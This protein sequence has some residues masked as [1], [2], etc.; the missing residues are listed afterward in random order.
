M[1]KKELTDKQAEGLRNTIM[2][3]LEISKS[4]IVQ[5]SIDNYKNEMAAIICGY[6]FEKYPEIIHE[7]YED[8]ETM[9]A[10]R[11]VA[12]R[13]NEFVDMLKQREIN[14]GSPDCLENN[15]E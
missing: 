14:G 9:E 7:A 5:T 10:L 12:D 1:S 4:L 3:T 6:V 11:E 2:D 8:S 13:H 15:G